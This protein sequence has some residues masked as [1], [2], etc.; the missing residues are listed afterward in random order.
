MA[1]LLRLTPNALSFL[2]GLSGPIVFWAVTAEAWQLA[3]WLFVY[4]AASDFIDGPIAR[5][6]NRASDLGTRVDHVADCAFV[7]LALLA[8][9][10]ADVGAVPLLLP[11]VQLIAF[12]EYAFFKSPSSGR[13]LPSK[14]GRYNGIAYFVIVGAVVTQLAFALD[15]IPFAWIYALGWVLI[16]S[17]A[18][19][20]GMRV[21]DRV[22]MRNAG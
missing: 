7:F 9:V 12:A 20:L 10:V 11:F 19:S 6:L 16:L 1:M 18:A 4:A 2:R 3:F 17:T 13:L 5:K 14:L 8:L 22:V 21:A 15:W